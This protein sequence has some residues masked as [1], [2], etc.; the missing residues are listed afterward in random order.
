MNSKFF[1]III[2][3]FFSLFF[4]LNNVYSAEN[5]PSNNQYCETTISN[6]I[7]NVNYFKENMKVT[8]G[9]QINNI[10][11]SHNADPRITLYLSLAEV[12]IS[13][14][15][16]S[17]YIIDVK[18]EIMKDYNSRIL[19]D[20]NPEYNIFSI[21]PPGWFITSN[22]ILKNTKN[23]VVGH[24]EILLSK[25]CMLYINFVTP[26]DT[27]YS[28]IWKDL[29]TSIVEIK[30]NQNI[31]LVNWEAENTN[32]LGLE[33]ILIGF[34]IPLLV[35]FIIFLLIKRT[36][37]PEQN[38]LV[39]ICFGLIII[40]S[41]L[42]LFF[43]KDYIIEGFIQK[44]YIEILV[45]LSFIILFSLYSIFRNDL[46]NLF[47]MIFSSIISI[48]LFIYQ[49]INWFPN[50]NLAILFSIVTFSLSIII[51]SIWKKSLYDSVDTD[52]EFSK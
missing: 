6:F 3:N 7:S 2:I 12:N 43:I 42:T 22:E 31:Q 50:K 20:K 40:I 44:K 28:N 19:E 18:Q 17:D 21:N 4:I 51:Y 8:N 38:I 39:K 24:G 36:I 46:L 48:T 49:Y 26:S 32:P 34:I 27:G 29:K 13:N 10:G 9:D 16:L 5:L 47:A 52:H 35:S 23:S 11:F 37:V 30:N 14:I 1:K 45:M 15:K 25:N 41:F 33:A